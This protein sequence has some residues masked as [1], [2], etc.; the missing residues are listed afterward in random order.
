MHWKENDARKALYE[1][2]VMLRPGD[3]GY[4]LICFFAD[5]F[6]KSDLSDALDAAITLS[7]GEVIEAHGR[8]SVRAIPSED[9]ECA[10]K[11]KQQFEPNWWPKDQPSFKSGSVRVGGITGAGSLHIECLIPKASY[12]NRISR[13]ADSGQRRDGHPYLIALD[14]EE[15]TSSY[16]DIIN[17]LHAHFSIWEHVSGVILFHRRNYSTKQV[18]VVSVI[19]NPYA[20]LPFPKELVAFEYEKQ[21]IIEFP[22]LANS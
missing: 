10:K 16:Q 19:V 14:A 12:M 11:N 20:L 15:M 7:P 1:F 18:W 6:N 3:F 4:N 21:H 8:W 5:V 17:E 22:W 13:K 9:Q 2:A